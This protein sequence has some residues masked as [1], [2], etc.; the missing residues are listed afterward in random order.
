MFFNIFVVRPSPLN[1]F[2]NFVYLFNM[3]KIKAAL[4]EFSNIWNKDF[5]S[6]EIFFNYLQ[7]FQENKEYLNINFPTMQSF[8]NISNIFWR[9]N[10]TLEVLEYIFKD[11]WS[12]MDFLKVI[13]DFIAYLLLLDFLNLFL[14]LC[15]ASQFY[16]L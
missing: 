8:L 7:C 15:R 12:S 14:K 6:T 10:G 2:E 1:F 11:M 16:F 13:Y 5:W 4:W 3:S 9:T